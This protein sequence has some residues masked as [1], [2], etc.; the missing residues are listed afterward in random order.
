ML[1]RRRRRCANIN[2]TMV[3]NLVFSGFPQPDTSDPQ[4]QNVSTSKSHIRHI[5]DAGLMLVQRR[6]L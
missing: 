1:A 4:L 6:G 3:Q 2:L 5:T